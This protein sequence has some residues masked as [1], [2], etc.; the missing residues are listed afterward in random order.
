MH[1]LPEVT[2]EVQ[3][4]F[5]RGPNG[6]FVMSLPP[7]TVTILTDCNPQP[8]LTTGLVPHKP[9][10]QFVLRIPELQHVVFDPNT[11]QPP[12]GTVSVQ[13]RKRG[14]VLEV[15]PTIGLNAQLKACGHGVTRVTGMWARRR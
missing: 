14:A 15:P 9:C 5:T 1:N 13:T 2:P 12:G 3:P 6:T 7:V 11:R 8:P 10:E 4:N